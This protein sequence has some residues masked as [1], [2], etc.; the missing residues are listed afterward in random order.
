MKILRHHIYILSLLSFFI[1]SCTA[2]MDIRTDN[3]GPVLCIYGM[4]SSNSEYQTVTLSSSAPYFD[5]LPNLRVSGASVKISDDRGDIWYMEEKKDEPGIYSTYLPIKGKPDRTY[6]LEVRCDF[7]EDGIEETYTAESYMYKSIPIDSMRMV[8]MSFFNKKYYNALVYVFEPPGR[9]YYFYRFYVNG[10]MMAD[11]ISEY[12]ITS[13][14]MFD[15]QYIS[16]ISFYN[17]PNICDYD[18]Y[19]EDVAKDAL[20]LTPGDYVE[21]EMSEITKEYFEFISQCQQE[22]NG[23]NPIF[24]GPASNIRTNIKG[25]AVGFFGTFNGSRASA[26]VPID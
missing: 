3:A 18:K 22:F 10:F 9:N 2:P 14:E 16:D 6:Y 13:D 4:V 21:I 24:G 19:D 12:L 25:G 1:S 15:G 23:E 17:F 20:F 11:K 7:D 26:I 8:P 5:T